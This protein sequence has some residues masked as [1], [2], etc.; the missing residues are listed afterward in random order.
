MAEAS[1]VILRAESG[2]FA[3][4]GGLR[5]VFVDER[6]ACSLLGVALLSCPLEAVSVFAVFEVLA[7]WAASAF[8]WSLIAVEL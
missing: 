3:S 7:P 8:L 2:F 5:F 1:L 4:E 6:E